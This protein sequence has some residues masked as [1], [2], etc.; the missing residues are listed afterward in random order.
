MMRRLSFT[1]TF[2]AAAMA[3]G[4]LLLAQAPPQGGGKGKGGDKADGKGKDAKGGAAQAAVQT[5][6]QLKPGLFLVVGAGGN[7]S[8]RVTKDGLIVGDTKNLGDPFYNGLMDQIKTVSALP[9]KWVVVTHHH[10][11]HS[12]NIK[13]FTDAG[14]QVVAHANLKKNLVTYAPQQGKPGDP[15]VTYDKK[16]SF[17]LGGVKAEVYHY[18]RAHTGGD[19]CLYYGDLKV[20]QCGDVVVGIAPNIDYPFGGSGLEWLK[21]LNGIA[22]LNFDTLIPGHSAP[23]A[24]T[25]TRADFDAYKKKWETFIARAQ[26]EAK[27]GTPKDKL[28]AAIK[29]DDIGWNVS[30]GVWVQPARL[31]PFYEEM[32]TGKVAAMK[33]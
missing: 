28:M 14:A 29:T 24:T 16:Y 31:D 8:V 18:G 7:T 3:A 9:V 22:K 15:T 10:Q 17:K 25:M 6:S 23:N 11:D 12:G 27:K 20:V 13:K 19:S 33:P 26:E 2:A 30:G 32:S 1:L 4:M 5:I 21:V